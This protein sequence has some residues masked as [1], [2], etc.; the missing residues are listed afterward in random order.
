MQVCEFPRWVPAS[1]TELQRGLGTRGRGLSV[2]CEQ[3][4]R[5][6]GVLKSWPS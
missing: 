3:E 2:G 5:G 1:E 6:L 4:T